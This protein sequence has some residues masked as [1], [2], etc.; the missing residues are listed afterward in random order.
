MVSHYQMTD[1]AAPR[2]MPKSSTAEIEATC[3]CG[4]VVLRNTFPRLES[5]TLKRLVC[6]MHGDWT[7]Y[8]TGKCLKHRE[9]GLYNVHCTRYSFIQLGICEEKILALWL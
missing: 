6:V 9:G 1:N 7:S 8:L 2:L 5:T 4:S 3:G